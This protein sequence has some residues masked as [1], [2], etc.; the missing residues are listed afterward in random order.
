LRRP[1][2]RLATIPY[3]HPAFFAKVLYFINPLYVVCNGKSR[4]NR[5]KNIDSGFKNDNF[6]LYSKTASGRLYRPGAV[7][8]HVLAPAFDEDLGAAGIADLAPL[9]GMADHIREFAV[10]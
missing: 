6:R 1:V 2:S 4:K 5:R 3:E 8:W 9:G 10:A 7:P